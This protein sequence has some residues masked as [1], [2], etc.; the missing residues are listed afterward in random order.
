MVAVSAILYFVAHHPGLA[1]LALSGIGLGIG[2]LLA[3]WRRQ[4]L[5]FGLVLPFFLFSGLS[6][7]IVPFA[8]ALFLNAFGTR[9]T[10]VI[11]HKQETNE[12]LNES[13]IWDYDAVLKAADGRDVVLQF[14]T[15]SVAIY[16]IRN[17]ILIP[18]ERDP[19]VVKYIPGF[20]SNVVIMCDESL[21]G[22]Q[23]KIERDRAPVEKAAGQYA[24][25]PANQAFIREYRAALLAFL[26]KHRDDADP[27][28]IEEY[29]QDLNTLGQN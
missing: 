2:A 21:Y 11:V 4:V 27:D 20:E 22:K 19:F 14:S 8:N 1:T 16:P 18:P 26:R 29:D 6:Y 9:A 5:W 3:L 15:T 23:R 17:E 12:M 7:F 24:V 10:A 25:N 28:L 13:Y